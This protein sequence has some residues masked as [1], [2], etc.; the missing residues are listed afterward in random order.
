MLFWQQLERMMLQH[1]NST[2]FCSYS[3]FSYSKQHQVLSLPLF[4]HAP[5]F[6][7]NADDEPFIRI[8][9]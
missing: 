5:F 3:L 1:L 9:V 2:F 7:T 8:I 4:L 6:T